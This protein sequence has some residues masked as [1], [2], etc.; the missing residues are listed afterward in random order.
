M[1]RLKETRCSAVDENIVNL[2][3]SIKLASGNTLL[4][5]RDFNLVKTLIYTIHGH[6]KKECAI[7][8]YENII[9]AF[10]QLYDHA[11]YELS[12]TKNNYGSGLYGWFVSKLLSSSHPFLLKCQQSRPED[13]SLPLRDIFARQVRAMET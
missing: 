5:E 1:P 4:A 2:R 13:V 10:C 3:R 11:V 7:D 6:D 9:G 12:R 8:S